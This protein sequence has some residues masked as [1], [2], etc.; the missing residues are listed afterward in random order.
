MIPYFDSVIWNT[1]YENH[2]KKIKHLFED[3]FLYKDILFYKI[4]NMVLNNTLIT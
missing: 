4:M 1:F 3:T 2:K